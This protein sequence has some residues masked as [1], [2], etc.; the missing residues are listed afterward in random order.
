[1][2]RFFAVELDA[3]VGL[4][5]FLVAA[6]GADAGLVRFFV[7]GAFVAGAGLLSCRDDSFDAGAGLPLGR[8]AV[9]A[10]VAGAGLLSF[11]TDAVVALVAAIGFFL[12][13]ARDR[14]SVV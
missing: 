3:G 6:L 10:L 12:R 4:T 14:K 8:F 2:L 13:F 1:M 9:A 11:F 5:R 7:P